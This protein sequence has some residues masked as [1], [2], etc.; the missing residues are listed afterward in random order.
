MVKIMSLMLDTYAII[1]LF[2]GEEKGVKVKNLLRKDQDVY[3]SVLSL[4]ELG[5]VLEKEIGKD[6]SEDYIRSLET[7]YTV[8]DV[9]SKIAKS[10]VSLKRLYK[11]PAVDCLI[12]ASAKFLSAKVVSGCKHF[13]S[14]SKQ[15]DVII[16]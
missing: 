7:Y 5:T 10:A 4:F 14:I 3:I 9:D 8:I 16:I 13:R 11:L 6:S 12:Y 15:K 1:E 2:R